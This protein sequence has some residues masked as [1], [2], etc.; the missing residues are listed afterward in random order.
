MQIARSIRSLAETLATHLEA[1][2]DFFLI[3]FSILF[4]SVTSLHALSKPLWY[5]EL[6]T[7]YMSRLPSMEAIWSALK[8]GAD[9]NPPLLYMATR[10]THA[11]LG[12]GPV[13]TRLPA[14]LGFLIMLLCLFF[15]VARE[16]AD[17]G[18]VGLEVAAQHR[19][20]ERSG[21][22]SDQESLGV[23]HG[24]GHDVVRQERRVFGKPR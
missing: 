10:T 2:R 21:P 15:F 4:I 14:L 7:L 20:A 3:S 9:L 13:A 11:L 8:D 1:G 19:V 5:D 6:F 12:D 16:D 24:A 22:A 18:D 17:L 23:E